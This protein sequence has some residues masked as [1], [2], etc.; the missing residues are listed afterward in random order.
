MKKIVLPIV[1][2]ICSLSNAQICYERL[3]SVVFTPMENSTD[4]QLD[5][6]SD[7]CDVHQFNSYTITSN[8]NN[9]VINLCY[10]DTGL[11]MPTTITSSIV[12]TG[13]NTGGDQNF[14]FNSAHHFNN[15]WP[16]PIDCNSTAGVYPIDPVSLTVTTPLTQARTFLLAE[17]EF[18][19]KKTSLYPNPNSGSFAL[20]LPADDDSAQLTITDLSGKMIYST[21]NYV[22]GETIDLKGLSNGLYFAKIVCNQA[23]ETLKFV[24]K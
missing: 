9:H 20:Q 19:L 13:L 16:N 7:C 22:S 10:L 2:L 21:S 24:V 23:T 17:S 11:L 12:L 4:I 8:G 14:T 1:L 18:S 15:N 5:I 6:T 3:K